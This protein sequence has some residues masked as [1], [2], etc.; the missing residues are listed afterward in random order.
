VVAQQ[1]Q[2]GLVAGPLP[3]APDGVAEAL[4]PLLARIV[5]ALA[6]VGQF[7]GLFVGPV[8]AAESPPKLR[9]HG[10]EVAAE[11]LLGAR[12]ADDADLFHPGSQGLLHHDLDDGFREAVPVNQGEELLAHGGRGRVLPRAE[13]GGGDDCFLDLRHGTR[14]VAEWDAKQVI[15]ADGRR[16]RQVDGAVGRAIRLARAFRPRPRRR[17]QALFVARCSYWPGVKGIGLKL[18]PRHQGCSGLCPQRHARPGQLNGPVGDTP[19]D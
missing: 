9:R 19:S 11:L 15:V 10:T 3:G 12:P 2:H 5:E 8:F 4:L 17:A 1:N 14:T 18:A 13:P 6:D 16:A 7:L